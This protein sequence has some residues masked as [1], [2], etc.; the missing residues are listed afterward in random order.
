MSLSA[1][2]APGPK[3]RTVRAD[4]GSVHSVPEGWALLEPGD[5]TLTRRVKAAGPSWT[6][7]EKQGRRTFSRGVW[8]PEETIRRLAAEWE[9]ERS[10]EAY[11]KKREAGLRRRERLQE[12]Y[13]EDFHGAVVE[14]LKFHPAHAP[15]ADRMAQRGLDARSLRPEQVVVA[16][17]PATAAALR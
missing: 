6:V 1:V 8:A 16:I 5:A 3:P 15:M 11:A 13:V 4:D 10:T 9:A 17:G 14:F 12:T 2:F 7:Q